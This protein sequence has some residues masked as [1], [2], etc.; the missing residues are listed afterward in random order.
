MKQGYF[1]DFSV[2][3]S[4]RTQGITFTEADIIDYAMRYDPQPFHTDRVAAKDSIYGGIIASGW[5]VGGLAFRMFIQSG[6]I[7]GSMG[8]PGMD[9]VRWHAPVRP[10]DTVH[11]TAEVT[12]IRP[13][14]IARG[15]RL[16]DHG[17]QSVQSARRKR[18]V[19]ARRPDRQPPGSLKSL[20][21]AWR[22]GLNSPGGRP[23]KGFRP[24]TR[25]D[26]EG[27]GKRDGW[28]Q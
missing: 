15:P 21:Y 23:S 17:L 2:G 6:V 20:T 27:A 7:A 19:L 26:N 13:L 3:E 8:S 14:V 9:E 12:K 18:H 4:F 24:A 22:Q 11:L 10:G 1:E 28:A 16:F 25:V 5:H